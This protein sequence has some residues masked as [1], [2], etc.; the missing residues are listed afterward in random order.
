M[1]SIACK[2]LGGKCKFLAKG[3]SAQEV[4]EKLFAH[5]RTDHVEMM[6]KMSPDDA[7]KLSAK[8][9]QLFAA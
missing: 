7:A 1:K 5:A 8:I 2:D 4:K 9:D 6:A 3:D